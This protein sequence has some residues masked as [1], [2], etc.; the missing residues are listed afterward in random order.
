LAGFISG[1]FML[2]YSAISSKKNIIHHRAQHRGGIGG[3]TLL[4]PSSFIKIPDI[5]FPEL[6]NDLF[7]KGKILIRL[8]ITNLGLF[9]FA[10]SIK[11]S[12]NI[13][14]YFFASRIDF[15]RMFEASQSF[16]IFPKLM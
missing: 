6:N 8:F 4:P 13:I 14:P 15:Q 1:S 7:K 2:S 16:L 3:E 10:Y 5:N 9:M 12:S 11:Y